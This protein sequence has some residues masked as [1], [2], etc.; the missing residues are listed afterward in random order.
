MRIS[1]PCERGGGGLKPAFTGES[2]V[3]RVSLRF[4][5]VLAQWERTEGNTGAIRK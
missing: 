2:G 1:S 4:Q 5:R 3:E